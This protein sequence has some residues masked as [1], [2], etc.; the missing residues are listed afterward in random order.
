MDFRKRAFI[1]TNKN[2]KQVVLNNKTC[3]GKGVD[4][5]TRKTVPDIFYTTLDN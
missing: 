2:Y 5:R 4:A 1:K 3:N